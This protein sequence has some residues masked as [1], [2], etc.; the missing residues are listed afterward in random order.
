MTIET[1]KFPNS[2]NRNS[3][4][5]IKSKVLSVS[6]MNTLLASL[7]VADARRYAILAGGLYH[8][9]PW[10]HPF[11]APPWYEKR[12]Y[13]VLISPHCNWPDKILMVTW[14][15]TDQVDELGE[16]TK[17]AVYN[18][19]KGTV[20]LTLNGKMDEASMNQNNRGFFW[21]LFFSW[22]RLENNSCFRNLITS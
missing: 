7:K 12:W 6:S 2:R 3:I 13:L 10:R 17:K 22:N 15:N 8:R 20:L 14:W 11:P 21:T 16:L 4:S 18:P 9:F 1:L 5:A 19:T